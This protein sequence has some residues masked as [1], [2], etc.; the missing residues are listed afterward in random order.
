MVTKVEQAHIHSKV[1]ELGFVREDVPLLNPLGRNVQ[2]TRGT[3]GNKKQHKVKV[4]QTPPAQ[5]PGN[6]VQLVYH[7]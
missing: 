7:L 3:E 2:V 6:K 5:S 1:S 4:H